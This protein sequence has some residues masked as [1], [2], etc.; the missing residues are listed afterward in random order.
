[1]GIQRALEVLTYCEDIFEG[2][3]DVKHAI[4]ILRQAEIYLEDILDIVMGRE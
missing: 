2:K 4:F 1:M 3:L